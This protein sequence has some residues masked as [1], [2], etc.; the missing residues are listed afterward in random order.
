MLHPSKVLLS[1]HCTR[2]GLVH[3]QILNES[4]AAQGL[5]TESEFVAYIG[6]HL[7]LH[8]IIAAEARIEPS[9]LAAARNRCLLSLDSLSSDI[10][11]SHIVRNKLVTARVPACSIRRGSKCENTSHDKFFIEQET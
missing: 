8:A 4:F 2:L 1:Y 10:E 5:V 9:P 7:P 3:I 6:L 11:I